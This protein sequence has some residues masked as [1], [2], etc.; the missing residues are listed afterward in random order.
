[1]GVEAFLDV[2]LV[3]PQAGERRFLLS[4][5]FHYSLDCFDKAVDFRQQVIGVKFSQ[6]L[7]MLLNSV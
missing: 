1:M 6:L 4:L 3:V 5:T 2:I 7:L